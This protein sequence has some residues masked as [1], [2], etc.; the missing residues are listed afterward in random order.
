MPLKRG[1]DNRP[2]RHIGVRDR[3]WEMPG[4]RANLFKHG[5]KDTAPK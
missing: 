4:R 1:A 3:D 2:I 5:R